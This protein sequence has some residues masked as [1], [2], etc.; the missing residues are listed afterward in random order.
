M[1]WGPRVKSLKAMEKSTGQPNPRLSSRPTL[2]TDVREYWSHY[3]T[4]ADSRKFNQA[5]VQPIAITEIVSY[6]DLA[7]IRRGEPALKFFRMIKALD[8]TYL[9]WWNKKQE[10]TRK[11]KST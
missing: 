4:I 8:N 7:G 9:T 3:L 5:G 11:G 6:I 1:E 10:P 2:R